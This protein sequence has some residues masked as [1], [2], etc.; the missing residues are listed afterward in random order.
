MSDSVEDG[1][2]PFQNH[3][4]LSANWCKV[5]QWGTGGTHEGSDADGEM[6]RIFEHGE[7]S[8]VDRP[9][10]SPIGDWGGLARWSKPV[11]VGLRWTVPPGDVRKRFF[12]AFE[13]EAF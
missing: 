7:H 1:Y 9:F 2:G 8:V 5:V 11:I 10:A 6:V 4:E 12:H 3:C 13:H